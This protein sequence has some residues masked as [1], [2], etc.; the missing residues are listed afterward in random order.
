MHRSI[1]TRILR[2]WVFG[3]TTSPER[4]RRAKRPSLALRASS[5]SRRAQVRPQLEGLEDRTLL[6]N[7]YTV[8]LVTDNV[9]FAGQ[10]TGQFSGDLRWCI[11]QADTHPGSTIAF[12]PNVFPS[13]TTTT[14]HLIQGELQIQASMNIEGPGAARSVVISGD[15]GGIAPTNN[16]PAS[17]VFDI[18]TPQAQ[19]TIANVTVTGGNGSP[20]YSVTAGNQGGDIFNAGQLVLQND[21]IQNGYLL[22]SISGGLS[23][24]GGGIF[25]AE[26]QNGSDGAT[27]TLYNTLVQ[28]NEAQGGD[29]ANSDYI[30]TAGGDAGFGAGGGVYNDSNATLSIQRGSQ[31]INNEALGGK[32]GNGLN[33]VNGGKNSPGSIGGSGGAG[34]AALG[35]AV[36]NN[37]GGS[38]S[39]TGA[40]SSS[41]IISGDVA[42]GGAGGNGD[43]G[44]NAGNATIKLRIGPTGGT[45]GT[46][47]N[48]GSALGGGLYNSGS[49]L[50]LEYAQFAGDQATGGAGGTGSYA[51]NAGNGG[52]NAQG[53]R[54]GAGGFGGSGGGAAGG[55]I[56]SAGS[57][58]KV[59]NSQ[60][61]NDSAIGGA[62]NIGS[63]AGTGGT[64]S[65]AGKP[66]F[67]IGGAGGT[68]GAGGNG[69]DALGGAVFNGGGN[70]SFTTVTVT[71]T[72]A[73]GG[74]GGTGGTGGQGGTGG[75][76]GR[77]GATG[78]GGV[79]GAGGTAQGGGVY[80]SGGSLT[81]SNFVSTNSQANGGSGGAAA[82]GG[83]GGHGGGGA[84]AT[85]STGSF[86]NFGGS[87]LVGG[88]GGAGGAGG[89]AQG[90]GFYNSGGALTVTNSQFTTD[91]VA[92]G[93]GGDGGSGGIGGIGG[94]SGKKGFGG[95]TG[96]IG[97]AGGDGGDAG[98][99]EGG[100]GANAGGNVAVT[101][102]YTVTIS[103]S[104]FNSD[105]VQAGNGGN[106]GDGGKGGE[107]G[108]AASSIG[109]S[110]AGGI[111]GNGG[112]GGSGSSAQGGGLSVTSGALDIST[113]T[114]FNSDQVLGGSGGNGGTGGV[115]NTS[116]A[117]FHLYFTE[118]PPF[119]PLHS[120]NG[121]DGGTGG[122][123]TNVS[124]GGLA[125]SPG[126]SQSSNI[127]IIT[128]FPGIDL[129]TS[130]NVS[131]PPDTQGA[132]GPSNY[133][134]T[135]NQ[136]IGI[137]NKSNGT[138]INTD[139]LSDF[140]FTQG[141]LARVS[142]TDEQTDS[143]IVYDT[144]AQRFI[145]GD[146]EFDTSA[147][148]G[149]ANALLL[150]VS[151]TNDPTTLTSSDWYFYEVNATL[152]NVQL[153]DY[154][155][156]VGYN[157]DALVITQN[158]FSTTADIGTFVNT[159]SMSALT[160]G[161]P[162]ALGTNLFQNE[163]TPQQLPILP[164]PV[165]MTNAQPGG[166]MWFVASAG[167][168]GES[169]PPSG[170]NT[171][172]VLEMNNVL[173]ANPTFTTTALNVNTYYQAVSP[174][175]PDGSPITNQTDSRMMNADEATVGGKDLIVADQIVSNAAGT[176]D[177]AR[178]YQID[179]SSGTPTLVQ[180][181]DV[182]GGPGVYDMYPGIAINSSGAIG[183]SYD[184]SG[185]ATGQFM[186]V[187]VAGRLP[188]DPAGT[189]GPGVLVQA[190]VGVANLPTARQGDM[191]GIN[192]DPT[193]G[194]F[195]IANEY[196]NTE[197]PFDWGTAIA[198]F[199]I[200]SS[201]PPVRTVTISDG[202]ANNNKLVGGN[203]GNGGKGGLLP[204]LDYPPSQITRPVG[205]LCGDGGAGGNGSGG[206]IFLSASALQI[207]TLSSVSASGNSTTGGVGGQ[208]A[209]QDRVGSGLGGFGGSDSGAG[210]AGGSVMGG[211]LADINYSLT[212]NGVSQFDNN[213][214]IAGA[215]GAGGGA[216][217]TDPNTSYGGNGSAGGSAVGGG[218]AFENDLAATLVLSITG[219]SASNNKMTASNG[220]AGGGAGTWDHDHILGGSGGAGGQ[221]LGGGLYVFAS[222]SSVNSSTLNTD[223][224]DNNTLTAGNGTNA[225]AGSSNP[226]RGS[227][228][229]G[230][231]AA[232]GNGGNAEGGGE[233]YNSLNTTTA[234]TQTIG[235]STMAGN[236]LIA[237]NGGL[238]GTGTT[239]NGGPGG[240]GGNGGN[241]E[242]GGF[243]DNN[244]ATLTVVNS[245]LGGAVM[246]TLT[247]GGTVAA[248]QVYTIT[249]GSSSLSYTATTTDTDSTI[250]S[251]LQ[252]LLST[253]SSAAFQE[254]T[255][256][257]N[258]N[259]ITA[260]GET[261]G[262][263]G[264]VAGKGTLIVSGP[265]QANSNL[266]TG[267]SG[268]A[269][270][271]GGTPIG[272]AH[273]DGGN[274]GNAGNVEGGGVY[275][276]SR[277]AQFINDSI[278]NNQ[279]ANLG[280]AGERGSGA[281]SGG[282]SGA[283]GSV[284]NAAGGGYFAASG[285][286]QVGNT[287]LDLNSALTTGNDAAGTFTSLGNNILSSTTGATGFNTGSGGT[288]MLATPAQLNLGP[289][290][291]NGGLT[292]TDALLSN[293]NGK[294][295]AAASGG[296]TL[297]TSTANPWYS[298][299]GSSPT[300]QRGPGFSRT[301]NN[302]ISSG[303]FQ[304]LPPVITSLSPSSVIEGSPDLTLTVTGSNFTSGATVTF[305]TGSTTII[306]RSSTQLVVL[307]PSALL[308]TPSTVPV[309]VNNPDG[310]GTG[311]AVKSS[312]MNFTI[313]PAPFTLNNPGNQQSY[314]GEKVTLQILSASGFIASNFS[315]TGL[316]A[317]LSID[318]NSG[319]ISGTISSTANTST[320]YSVTV[321]ATDSNGDA[322]NI[323][324][325]WTV[326][327]PIQLNPVPNQTNNEGDSVALLV[328]APAGYTPSGFT[329][330]GLPTG[331]SINPASGLISGKIDPYAA[332]TF[333]VTV[334]PANTNGQGGVSFTW[335]VLD[336]TPPALTNPGTQTSAAGQNIDLPI[337][338]VD[339][340]SGS[341]TA[342]GLPPG[343]LID[344]NGVIFG[345]IASSAQGIY[346]VT[347]QA[348][349]GSVLS[350]PVS[351]FWNVS[352]SASTVSPPSSPGTVPPGAGVATS[353]TIVNV[354][355][356]YTGLLQLETVTVD[357]AS[358]NGSIVNEGVVTIQVDGQTSYASVHSG[359]ATATFA[360]G[361]LDLSLWQ[362]LLFSHPLTAGYSDSA[363]GFAASGA[364]T[365]IEAIWIDYLM[366]LLAVD[367]GQLTQL[368]S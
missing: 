68:G 240:N 305:G 63:H 349:D 152:P 179:V 138:I 367:I 269:G 104:T 4:K 167:F 66:A 274:G 193:D 330:T 290:L 261:G 194:S 115:I 55:A 280:I 315:A 8:N 84:G 117:P 95:G 73:Q 204:N 258:G 165:T 21:V 215:G 15:A 156:N 124:G 267:G 101:G 235:Y 230:S 352:G 178:W 245:T 137:Y 265:Q 59:L 307:V 291:N 200:Q 141:G 158:S 157:A 311:G 52:S 251:A 336:T 56:Y 237:G 253:S 92:S 174:L 78:V 2:Q 182:S 361:L 114:T 19:V 45:G 188:T 205:G 209:I 7:T 239:S 224:L 310:S 175:Q 96:G 300:D 106:G 255:W 91:S 23:A 252:S 48:G 17:R 135:V 130:S 302:T 345:T 82:T 322:T 354:S 273:A 41:I 284:G 16:F 297:V 360:T 219:A 236:L 103:G 346:A 210:G 192:V 139:S 247:V 108:D 148:N 295:V 195:W 362:D 202:T 327:P 160:S 123:G 279:A 111:G 20:T 70:V 341:W 296:N 62:G 366:T 208:G 142:A 13:G 183:M 33:G 325:T 69:G 90:G 88:K 314:V 39:I 271:D 146:L 159:I 54:G 44:G 312:P 234:G 94:K 342:T 243:F 337:Q 218:I 162:L 172:D 332:G 26:G 217:V 357:V 49:I 292:P 46:G 100:G 14:I 246:Y 313:Q 122:A 51:G 238:G 331:L 67:E 293:A 212:V 213:I 289:L 107:G 263:S 334:S 335:T 173:S 71:G 248:G 199:T 266:L 31:I 283:A 184:Q 260:T 74:A 176:E 143:F 368:Q 353:T 110:G 72:L 79:G 262:I 116:G 241:A 22:G 348:S 308:L 76:G 112:N 133:I 86:A 285:A 144:I 87:G 303:A 42:Q 136:A 105:K 153:Q 121:G 223:T 356:Q 221:A 129:N 27:L 89:A 127:K 5:A 75:A 329:A 319:T 359:Q 186:S 177:N 306:S 232:G 97:G 249:I 228:T 350:S 316:P 355:N 81:L 155:G 326:T 309:Y 140:F 281:G 294:S 38:V 25:N 324:F 47:G 85:K 198:H 28:N 113:N 98:Y 161:T 304:F 150:A 1:W 190:G 301:F 323:T 318:P 131:T 211:G 145:A 12:D 168:G 61:T 233:Y 53:G 242:G 64:G 29:G 344:A 10:Q 259:V 270:N 32:G 264:S 282:N 180:E 286:N 214:G 298:L 149:A 276:N 35:G 60:F 203:G 275:V 109:S 80:N 171:I 11:E 83:I 250:A 181:G 365:M 328:T 128:D 6:S 65:T 43:F 206:G 169:I 58:F 364:G 30:S 77:G 36:F 154:P 254:Y 147:G 278:V 231:F 229:V 126:T 118:E 163:Y 333:S 24:R 347:V 34:G 151:K 93:S 102:T 268:G 134:E 166:P 272:L 189:M 3:A 288:D 40:N 256:V 207:A 57:G 351:F 343:L 340:D 339:A 18:T 225:G 196:A 187:Y 320:P 226:I 197:A 277:S 120:P 227:T 287:L 50:T 119:Y 244:T 216:S 99:A 363:R 321:S 257:V 37:T 220:G 125:V 222:S 201:P 170:A 185:T 164:R 299:F 358:A 132:A 9:Q 338:A 317:G 191:S